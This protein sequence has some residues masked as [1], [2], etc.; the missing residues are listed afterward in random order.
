MAL[1]DMRLAGLLLLLLLPLAQCA[2]PDSGAALQPAHMAAA[3]VAAA[4]ASVAARTCADGDSVLAQLRSAQGDKTGLIYAVAGE[5]DITCLATCCCSHSSG[6][7]LVA[8]AQ[9]PLTRVLCHGRG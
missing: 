1:S 8:H 3:S 2:T 6:G 9:R 7:A 5:D 4:A